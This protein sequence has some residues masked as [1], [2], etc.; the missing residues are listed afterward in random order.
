MVTSSSEVE[1]AAS[2][3]GT[4]H[5]KSRRPSHETPVS[6]GYVE[7]FGKT[8]HVAGGGSIGSGAE[9]LVGFYVVYGV[10]LLLCYCPAGTEMSFELVYVYYKEF[11]L[12]ESN[13]KDGQ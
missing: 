3:E 9:H 4:G 13:G 5:G 8:S 1:E 10:H 6:R 2:E 7:E 12:H 11:T